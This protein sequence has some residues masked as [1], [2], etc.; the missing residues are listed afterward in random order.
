[1]ALQD[2]ILGLALSRDWLVLSINL[3]LSTIIGGIVIT[4]LVA[5]AGRAFREQ[6]KYQNAFL[7][8]FVI[9]LISF[10]GI[11]ALAPSFPLAALV[12]PVLIW[13][14]LTK[15]FFSQMSILHAV[16]VGLVGY[17][18]SIFLIPNLVGLVSGFIPQFNFF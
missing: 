2:Q 13:I 4:V 5:T 17:G 3:I 9:N 8:V 16:I 7:M 14:G 6:V 1:M 15:A 10:L 12:L 11:L 18:L